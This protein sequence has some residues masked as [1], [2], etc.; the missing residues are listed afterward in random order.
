M[1]APQGTDV[2]TMARIATPEEMN[3]Y[4]DGGLPHI[5]GIKIVETAAGRIVGRLP[6]KPEL[7]ARNGALWAPAV[8]ALAD[9]LCAYGVWTVAPEGPT[10]F[11]TIELKCNFMSTI[12]GGAAL[13]VAQAIHAG[14]QTQVWDATVTSE[15]TGKLMA[16]FRNTQM[17]LWP[18]AK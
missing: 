17:L 16:S 2:Q 5:L 15:E 10:G 9:T 6:V 8:V 12:I 7:V 14:R 4:N 1:K 18:R 11:T 13:C 3:T